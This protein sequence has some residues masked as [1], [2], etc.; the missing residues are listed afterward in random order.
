MIIDAK[1]TSNTTIQI[2]VSDTT[3]LK[4]ISMDDNETVDLTDS[5][6]TGSYLETLILSQIFT[7]IPNAIYIE[8][9]DE[10]THYIVNLS[11]YAA[12]LH[13]KTLSLSIGG[14]GSVDDCNKETMEE[15]FRVK[16]TFDTL[17]LYHTKTYVKHH[18]A[19]LGKEC[20]LCHD[21]TDLPF[22]EN[23]QLVVENDQILS[24]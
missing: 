15:A 23:L 20:F 2:N 7:K 1:Y 17:R 24:L 4:L 5:L 13:Q 10:I 19:Q 8:I 16:L 9:D 11:Y 3:S 22:Q 6:V 14:C 18:V 21:C 12:C